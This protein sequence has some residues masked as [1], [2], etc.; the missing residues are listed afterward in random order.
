MKPELAGRMISWSVELSKFGLKFEPRGSIKAQCLADF[1]SELQ[2]QEHQTLWM[3]YVDGSSNNKQCRAGVVLESPSRIK[4]EQSLRFNFKASNNQ[5]EYEAIIADL[6]LAEDMGARQVRC[7]TDSLLTVEQLNDT[8]QVKGPLLTKYYQK[9]ATL[10]PSCKNAR[11]DMPSKLALGKGKGKFDTIIQLTITS[12]TVTE[13]DCM[14][15]ETIENWR[16]PIIQ[17]LKALM[18]GEAISDKALAK[19]AARYVFISE[20][21]YKN[22]LNM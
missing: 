20:D 3:L 21:L 8:F 17:V 5:A 14:N 16:M 12:P 10:L 15:V 9:V 11:A 2:T 1:A 13:V 4:V 6:C 7:L 19:K 18:K 22:N